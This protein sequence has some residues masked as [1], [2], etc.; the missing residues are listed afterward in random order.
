MD[1]TSPKSDATDETENVWKV[2]PQMV[3]KLVPEFEL[4]MGKK[5]DVWP[6]FTF[7]D[8]K[9]IER[10][11]QKVLSLKKEFDI[12]KGESLNPESAKMCVEIIDKMFRITI[13]KIPRKE[14][15]TKY[16][17]EKI[18]SYSQIPHGLVVP[19]GLD[20]GI[21]HEGFRI[22]I[23]ELVLTVDSNSID[24]FLKK[25][26][27][28]HRFIP[29]IQ[30]VFNKIWVPDE[31]NMPPADVSFESA[32]KLISGLNV[33][34]MDWDALTN[35]PYGLI[36][37]KNGG[38]STKKDKKVSL[39]DKVDKIRKEKQLINL[40]KPEW[41]TVR[42]SI[43]HATVRFNPSKG[44]IDFPDIKREVNWKLD[45]AYLGAIDIFLAN[46]AMLYIFNFINTAKAEIFEQQIARLKE[47]AQ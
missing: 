29:Q 38:K 31:L 34:T 25:I 13:P 42:N 30:K 1:Q 15:P 17:I 12:I 24:A 41:V 22:F 28:E 2:F 40:A 47:T 7:A 39:W 33:V 18:K 3:D 20:Y 43:A 44:C 19:D 21:K 14:Q 10:K 6:T 26:A 35:V 16:V 36:E 5:I 32:T 23:K 9:K 27:I 8:I 46:T 4:L 11:C 37:L 45:E